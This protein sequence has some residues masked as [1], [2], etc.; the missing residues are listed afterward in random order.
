MCKT[1]T[2]NLW[3]VAQQLGKFHN[4]GNQDDKE[5]H[6]RDMHTTPEKREALAIEMHKANCDTKHIAKQLGVNPRTI[7]RYIKK[8]KLVKN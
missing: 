6:A 5:K 2:N 8:N 1:F 7:Q 3:S 4:S